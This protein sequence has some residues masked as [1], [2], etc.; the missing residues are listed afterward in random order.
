MEMLSMT[1]ELKQFLQDNRSLIER[2]QFY[3]LYMKLGNTIGKKNST[4][5]PE[6]TE[7]L[8]N[9]DMDPLDYLPSVPIGYMKCS[10][11]LDH[12]R[13]PDHIE[14]VNRAAFICSDLKTVTFGE[15]SKCTHIMDYAFKG[16]ERLESVILP[17]TCSHIGTDAFRNCDWLETVVIPTV[18]PKTY[19]EDEAFAYC[20]Y[21]T[22]YCNPGPVE[23]YCIE[24]KLNYKLLTENKRTKIR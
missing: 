3:E 21:L 6:L 23:N 15:M 22:I 17:K 16:S 8:I 9:C 19:I 13:I 1:K 4:Y 11:L 5:T 24:H 12:I 2:E 18:D 7:F 20:P 10:S 14:M